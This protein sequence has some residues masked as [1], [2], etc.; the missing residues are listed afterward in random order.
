MK[1]FLITLFFCLTI[2]GCAKTVIEL[3][4]SEGSIE[5][6]HLEKRVESDDT[7]TDQR[8]AFTRESPEWLYKFDELIND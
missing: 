1:P 7:V 8:K 4:Y 5:N 2:V 3:K 6:V